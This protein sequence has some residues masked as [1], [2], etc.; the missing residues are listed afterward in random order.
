V[1]LRHHRHESKTTVR[2]YDCYEE[3]LPNDQMVIK[4][5]EEQF[6]EY[7]ET[8]IKKEN[9][10]INQVIVGFNPEKKSFMLG[11]V[12]ER[13]DTGHRYSI[14]WSDGSLNKQKEEHLF[15]AFNRR[16][17]HRRDYYVLA[18]DDSDEIYKPAKTISILND[19]KRL[20]VEFI[21]LDRTEE[22]SSPRYE[23]FSIHQPE[24]KMFFFVNLV[25]RIANVPATTTFV[26]TKDYLNTIRKLRLLRT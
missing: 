12:K 8:R 10:L 7:A 24:K 2:F 1:I 14:E 26:I 9:L 15:G 4:I 22:H 20:E 18:M 6:K 11:T 5:T 16:N 13:V 23:H 19:Q 25:F 17:K 3:D 21:N